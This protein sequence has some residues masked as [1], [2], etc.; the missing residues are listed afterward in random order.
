MTISQSMA[1]A[2]ISDHAGWAIVVCITA[3]RDLLDARR[4][5]LVGSGL[6]SLPH[7]C[8]GQRL[9]LDDAVALVE[10][11]RACAKT[12]AARALDALPAG[13]ESIAIR[14]RPVLPATVAERITSYWANARADTVMYRDVLAEAASTRG[15]TVYEFEAKTVLAEAADVLGLGDNSAQWLKQVG[16]KLGP[17]WR[18]DHNLATAAA[19]VAATRARGRG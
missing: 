7:H 10:R 14:K 2:G 11:V 1:A 8:E 19:L 5:E 4:I 15:W 16:Q 6:P 18:K 3:N 12:C 13:V 17:P 9:P